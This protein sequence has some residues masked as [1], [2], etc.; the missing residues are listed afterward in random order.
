M[1]CVFCVLTISLYLIIPT[2]AA[3]ANCPDVTVIVV[4][5][6]FVT[7][8]VVLIVLGIIGVLIYKRRRDI[9]RT[10]RAK[11]LGNGNDE[12]EFAYSNPA[13]GVNESPK[14]DAEEGIG[15]YVHCREASPLQ[16]I[17]SPS[18][19]P[20]TKDAGKTWMSLP[21]AD[22]PG[23]GLNRSGSIGSLDRNYLTGDPEVTSVWLHS[24]DFIGLGF[25]IAGSMRDG[26]FVSQVHNR[27]PAVESGKFRVGDRIVSVTV[28]FENMVYEDALT[29]LSYASPYPVQ[30]TLQKEKQVSKGRRVSDSSPNLKHP[31][32]RSQSVDTLIR[33][34]KENILH[35]KRCLSE[36]GNVKKES[37]EASKRLSKTAFENDFIPELSEENGSPSKGNNDVFIKPITPEIKIRKPVAPDTTVYKTK[38]EKAQ[39]LFENRATVDAGIPNATVDLSSTWDTD[40]TKIKKEIQHKRDTVAED[41]VDFAN[42][43]DQLTEQDKLDVIRISY[44]D[45]NDRSNHENSIIIHSSVPQAESSPIYVDE[46]PKSPP[47]KPERKKKK[48]SSSSTQSLSDF[49]MPPDIPDTAPP[50]EALVDDAIEPEIV[51]VTLSP[52]STFE[53]KIQEEKIT[54]RIQTRAK[55]NYSNQIDF[56]TVVM[57]SIV[58]DHEILD[59]S[60]SL[61]DDFSSTLTDT[62]AFDDTTLVQ[63]P[64]PEPVEEEEI[65]AKQSHRDTFEAPMHWF[66]F[67][68]DQKVSEKTVDESNDEINE[69]DSD[70]SFASSSTDKEGESKNDQ[71]EVPMPQLPFPQQHGVSETIADES[72]HE[73]KESDS[74]ASFA[75]SSSDEDKGENKNYHDGKEQESN[76][77]YGKLPPLDMNL[78]F[79]TDFF[80]E[81]FPSRNAKEKQR[82][83]SYDISVDEF[84]A[85]EENA[86]KLNAKTEKPKGGIAFEIRDDIISGI[87]QTVTTHNLHRTSSNDIVS[88][89]KE[90]S[91]DKVNHWST[92]FKNDVKK[93]EDVTVGDLSG[94]RLVKSGSFSD[95]P[96]NDSVNDWTKKQDFDMGDEVI[97]QHHRDETIF[98]GNQ[99]KLKKLQKATLFKARDNLVDISDSDLQCKSVSSMSSSSEDNSPTPSNQYTSNG[100]DDGLG[101]SPESSPIKVTPSSESKV[102]LI[103]NVQKIGHDAFTITVN[104]SNDDE[105]HC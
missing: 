38:N 41:A 62:S 87:P 64:F 1:I 103:T 4:V 71:Y 89:K 18:K 37:P 77:E 97:E 59:T 68:S 17:K 53:D 12:T 94:T 80:K 74:D 78:N 32:Y 44:I 8:A 105:D 29:I 49:G 93:P 100:Q 25:N 34:G 98:N 84:N 96:Q 81:K 10:S 28:S 88:M 2:V 69:S 19:S 11:T 14:R 45:P 48:G 58:N 9:L 86:L 30:V 67:P 40:D 6:V 79:D 33:L 61:A 54:P 5:S 36:S 85:M 26:I 43:F 52:P 99:L 104:A 22:F 73:S 63:S 90:S 21:K 57:E 23:P 15:G 95:I 66:M 13:F 72:D 65:A 70:A 16:T 60:M 7:L 46:E 3:E 27:G 55:I 47:S 76:S 75:S 102:D 24:Q 31:L 50:T 39:S 83:L 91:G 92:S 35:P 82:G 101:T 51:E 56:E 20:E 42:V